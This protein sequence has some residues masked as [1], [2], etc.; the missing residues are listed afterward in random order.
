ML[1]FGA[2]S[3][4]AVAEGG[5]I[6]PV[7]PPPVV[8]PPKKCWDLARLLPDLNRRIDDTGELKAFIEDVLQPVMDLACGDLERFVDQDDVTIADELTVDAMLRDLGNPFEVVFSQSLTRKRLVAQVL[9]SIYK[10]KGTEPSV[11]DIVRA[12]TG[13]EIVGIISPPVLNAWILGIDVLGDTPA[14]PPPSDPANTDL[15]ILGAGTSFLRFSFQVEVDRVL[16]T[17]ERDLLTEIIRIVKPAHT[18]FLGFVEPSVPLVVD[19]WE[20]G[21][22]FL[23]DTGEPLLG[24]E[25][26]LH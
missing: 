17:D 20:L 5:G 1:G 21:L 8:S 10:R 12:I 22:S 23:H 13:L 25:T 6:P 7:I 9:I 15:A 2:V 16:T 18:H 14:D 19:H 11:A 26:V 3:E 24:D 4:L